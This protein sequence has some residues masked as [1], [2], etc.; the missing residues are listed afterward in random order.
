MKVRR[1]EVVKAVSKLMSSKELEVAEI[2]KRAKELGDKAKE[3]T[4]NG[5]SSLC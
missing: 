5:G 2:R 1:D 3:A 4:E